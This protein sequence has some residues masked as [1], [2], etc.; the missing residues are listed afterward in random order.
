MERQLLINYNPGLHSS[1]F[2]KTNIM[3]DKLYVC[4]GDNG[5]LSLQ[6]RYEVDSMISNAE[7]FDGSMS[8]T[9]VGNL[10]QPVVQTPFLIIGSM[11]NNA[12]PSVVYGVVEAEDE[13]AA[14]TAF[15]SN[16]RNKTRRVKVQSVRN[17]TKLLKEYYQ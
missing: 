1:G 4:L 17:L 15:L 12:Q 10:P 9:V 11:L 5:E 3:V 2:F 6:S 8:F 16:K 13:E 14:K 7:V